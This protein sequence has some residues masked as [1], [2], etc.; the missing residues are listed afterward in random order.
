MASKSTDPSPSVVSIMASTSAPV[1][2]DGRPPGGTA[3]TPGTKTPRKVQ[4]AFDEREKPPGPSP[5]P[6]LSR[7]ALDELGLDVSFI[8]KTISRTVS[9][10]R[11]G[12]I[13]SVPLTLSIISRFMLSL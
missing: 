3:R 4:W 10:M 9:R 8:L 7:H 2:D 12:N 13:F 6:S 1:N 5:D 11:N